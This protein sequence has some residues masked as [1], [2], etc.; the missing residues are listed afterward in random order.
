[1][2][3][4]RYLLLDIHGVLTDGKERERLMEMMEK[5]YGM[6]KEIHNKLWKSHI[7][8]LDIG[9]EKFE[10][11]VHAINNV[12]N[13]NFTTETYISMFISNIKINHRILNAIKNSK[14]EI[15]IVSDT[16]KELSDCYDGLFNGKFKS[17]RKFY[18]HN[19]H[20]IKSEG[21]FEEVLNLI[22]AKAEECL[23]IDDNM[24]NIRA[25][26]KR[27]ISGVL[28]SPETQEEILYQITGTE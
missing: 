26:E 16:F 3:A 13:K 2:T 7:K 11:Y 5:E 19:L 4:L 21:A 6:D 25:A 18:S 24:E 27:N 1:M 17:Y 14:M 10:E 23:L 12:F 9:T 22:N 28:A 20:K 15:C 8:Q